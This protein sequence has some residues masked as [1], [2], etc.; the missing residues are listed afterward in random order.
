MYADPSRCSGW[1]SKMIV[2]LHYDTPINNTPSQNLKTPSRIPQ[3]FFNFAPT[4][5]QELKIF[6]QLLSL[7]TIC[8]SFPDF[9]RRFFVS[10]A[11]SIDTFLK[12]YWK[13]LRF[14]DGQAG[15]RLLFGKNGCPRWSI[16][17][18]IYV[19]CWWLKLSSGLFVWH[20]KDISLFPFAHSFFL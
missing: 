8:L 10:L 11:K 18:Y 5:L 20:D 4:L 7:Y 9:S 15:V 17:S 14:P 2:V 16:H 6:L 1:H 13:T 19:P 12:S 3:F